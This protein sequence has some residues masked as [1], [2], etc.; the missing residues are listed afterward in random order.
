M[1]AHG[2]GPCRHMS[3]I[4]DGVKR[5]PV[6]KVFDG[7]KS[8]SLGCSCSRR[9]VLKDKTRKWKTQNER[10]RPQ[11]SGRRQQPGEEE[12]A[13]RGWGGPAVIDMR[14]DSRPW[15]DIKVT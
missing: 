7:P 8:Q 12:A 9:L 1:H 4:R 3:S 11:Q 2:D 13:E 14:A 15:A 6:G 10:V 5:E